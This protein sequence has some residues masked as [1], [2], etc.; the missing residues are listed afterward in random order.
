MED[1]HWQQSYFSCQ[2]FFN[3]QTLRARPISRLIVVPWY[4]HWTTF[5]GL[6]PVFSWETRP[7][8]RGAA[9]RQL[10]VPAS[11]WHKEGCRIR[12]LCWDTFVIRETSLRVTFIQH[13]G[14][15]PKTGEMSAHLP[16]V[17]GPS[18]GKIHGH[19]AGRVLYCLVGT[20]M[21]KELATDKNLT[22]NWWQ[23]WKWQKQPL[24]TYDRHTVHMLLLTGMRP[25]KNC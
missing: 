2:V 7:E 17:N 21:W 1:K 18:T 6:W 19:F 23:A 10:Q 20:G 12:G 16:G 11:H 15:H 9:L 13:V 8:N 22:K 24:A 3:L 14:R 25:L 4:R 5:V